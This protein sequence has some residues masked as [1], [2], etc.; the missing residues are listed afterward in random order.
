M[1]ALTIVIR[2]IPRLS[3]RVVWSRGVLSCPFGRSM[4]R[5]PVHFIGSDPSSPPVFVGR[6]VVSGS[7]RSLL[8]SFLF[9]FFFGFDLIGQIY[10]ESLVLFLR[11]RLLL[12]GGRDQTQVLHGTWK[13]TLARHLHIALRGQVKFFNVMR[14]H[15][16]IGE[17]RRNKRK[18]Q[19][20]CHL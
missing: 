3:F 18:T 17:K 10:C 14:C 7:G 19:S 6:I 15:L 2:I 16:K 5:S 9:I 1:I 4:G 20:T 12:F 11:L 8:L 13:R